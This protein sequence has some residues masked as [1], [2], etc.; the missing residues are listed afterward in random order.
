MPKGA[1]RCV[2]RHWRIPASGAKIPPELLEIAKGNQSK[3]TKFR[4]T[5][6]DHQA[7]G[8]DGAT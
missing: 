8:P 1:I 7:G 4:E 5:F 3:E 2:C 6:N